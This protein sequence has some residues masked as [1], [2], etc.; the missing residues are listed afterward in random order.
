MDTPKFPDPNVCRTRHIYDDVCECLLEEARLC[1][2]AFS[3]GNGF[4]CRHPDCRAFERRKE[5]PAG[6]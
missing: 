5:S 3:F 1:G 4:F 6:P 2:Y